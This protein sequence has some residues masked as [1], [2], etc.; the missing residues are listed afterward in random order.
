MMFMMELVLSMLP[1]SDIKFLSLAFRKI[2]QLEMMQHRHAVCV[3]MSCVYC[4]CMLLYNCLQIC[5]RNVCSTN[6][7][8]FTGMSLLACGRGIDFS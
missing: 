8:S 6:N 5:S 7:N 1:E 2:N 3:H 4:M